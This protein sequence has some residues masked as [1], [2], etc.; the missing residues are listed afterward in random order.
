MAKQTKQ[1][2][3]DQ[4]R[5]AMEKEGIAEYKV[6]AFEFPTDSGPEYLHYEI[7]MADP[8]PVYYL[9]DIM[10]DI[11]Q[12]VVPNDEENDRRIAELADL[13]GGKPMTPNLRFL[14]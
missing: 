10:D 8:K 3:A 13:C 7:M 1:T 14:C 2:K 11:A 12:I 5:K 9:F 4:Y 6:L